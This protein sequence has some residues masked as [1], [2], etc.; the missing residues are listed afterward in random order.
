MEK[1]RQIRYY[2]RRAQPHSEYNEW[3]FLII[4][5]NRE[6]TDAEQKIY[7]LLAPI[8]NE[9][10]VVEGTIQKSGLR[11]K[12]INFQSKTNVPLNSLRKLVQRV[13]RDNKLYRRETIDGLENYVITQIES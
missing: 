10:P 2:C 4:N 6:I 9:S 13:V 7:S 8:E 11:F 3:W 5:Q 12:L 1:E